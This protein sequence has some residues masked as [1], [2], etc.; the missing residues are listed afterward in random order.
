MNLLRGAYVVSLHIYHVPTARYIA[1]AHKVTNFFVE[2]AVSWQ[3]VAHLEPSLSLRQEL[4]AQASRK[5]DQR[6]RLH[7]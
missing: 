6:Y 4:I 3:G 5:H 2:E 7:L 1:R